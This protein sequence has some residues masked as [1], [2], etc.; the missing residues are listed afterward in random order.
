M[1]FVFLVLTMMLASC[2]TPQNRDSVVDAKINSSMST[3]EKISP[4]NVNFLFQM[5]DSRIM[6]LR[7]AQLAEKKGSTKAIKEYAKRMIL[8]QEV[9]L[10]E[11][12]SLAQMNGVNLPKEMSDERKA[13][14][15]ALG[16]LTGKNF[17]N[18][19]LNLMQ[20]NHEGDIQKLSEVKA[21]PAH[22]N[23]TA[24]ESYAKTRITML[25]EHLALLRA[26]F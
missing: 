4:S 7:T 5:A 14:V 10:E 21:S 26:I 2:Q 9:M 24:I 12:K 20:N 11:I 25:Q 16:K 18:L 8:D 17:N 13:A 3:E 1:K 15:K 6:N 22:I 19:Y 23:D